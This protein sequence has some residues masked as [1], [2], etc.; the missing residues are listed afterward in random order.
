MNYSGST[1]R[2]VE[3]KSTEINTSSNKDHSEYKNIQPDSEFT[4]VFGLLEKV[5]IENPELF[6]NIMFINKEI[7]KIVSKENSTKDELKLLDEYYSELEE[8]NED[9][10]IWVVNKGIKCALLENKNLDLI[11]YFFIKKDVKVTN[12]NIHKNILIDFFKSLSE[13]NFIHS[14][15]FEMNEYVSILEILIHYAKADINERQDGTLNSPLHIAIYLKQLQF[16]IVLL[17]A[18]C[19]VNVLNSFDE[20]PLDMALEC[21]QTSKE[22]EEEVV[23]EELVRLLVAYGGEAKQN[24]SILNK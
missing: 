2:D 15:D 12:S 23:Y 21:F 16:V 10:L 1:K 3:I 11:H 6:S 7:L 8:L 17:K 24:N 20:T 19:D 13:V 4:R 5:R 22:K 14:E 9:F 18:G